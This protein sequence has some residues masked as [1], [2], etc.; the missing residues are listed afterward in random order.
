MMTPPTEGFWSIFFYET[1]RMSYVHLLEQLRTL[2][3]IF[4]TIW[5]NHI[6]IIATP[7]SRTAA[8]TFTVF[9]QLFDHHVWLVGWLVGW[10]VD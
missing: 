3:I 7:T 2:R 6:F 10:L 5:K 9:T 4:G 8:Q 1:F